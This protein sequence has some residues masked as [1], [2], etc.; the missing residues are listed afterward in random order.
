M[1]R[2]GMLVMILAASNLI[3]CASLL[4]ELKPHRLHRLNRHPAPSQDPE[5][6]SLSPSQS[7]TILRAQSED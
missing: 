7:P 4:H 1:S 2:I 6:T 3:G 5:F